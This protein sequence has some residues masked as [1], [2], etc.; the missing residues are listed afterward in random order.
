MDVKFF[1]AIPW[2][3]PKSA[4]KILLALKGTIDVQQISAIE[5]EQ[6]LLKSIVKSLQNLGY[7]AETVKTVITKYPNP[8]TKEQ[9]SEV[10]KRAISHL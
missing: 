7:E 9:I 1:Q 4:K 8:I 3:G 5:G 2:I 6:K 10:I